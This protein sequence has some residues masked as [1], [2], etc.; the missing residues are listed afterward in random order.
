MTHSW[1]KPSIRVPASTS[2]HI[3][4]MVASFFFVLMWVLGLVFY[5]KSQAPVPSHFDYLARPDAWGDKNVFLITLAVASLVMLLTA[6]SAY[7]PRLVNLPVH[8]KPECI[9]E[10]Y[11]LMAR[12]MRVLNIDLGLMFL[13]VILTQGAPLLKLNVRIFAVVE[14]VCIAFIFVLTIYY[15]LKIWRIGRKYKYFE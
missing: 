2:D 13:S 6:A 11:A 12:M 1:N 10:Q 4:E 9:H 15:S 3:L 7:Y 14:A 5:F 8:L